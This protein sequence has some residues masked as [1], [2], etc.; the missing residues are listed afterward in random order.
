MIPEKI[1]FTEEESQII[2]K[3]STYY[4]AAKE[5][6][7]YGEQI[8]PNNRTLA[9][10]LSERSN[11]L[12]HILRVFLEKQGLRDEPVKDPIAYNRDSLNKAYGHIY[13]AAYDALDWVALT[14][15]ERLAKD[16]NSVSIEA[17][18][19]V[20]PEYYSDIKPKLEKILRDDITSLRDHKD[21]TDGNEDNL[22]SY[23]QT[24]VTIRQLFDKVQEKMSSLIEYNL[25]HKRKERLNLVWQ[26][27]IAIIA[28]IVLIGV[29]WLIAHF[30]GG[31]ATKTT[32]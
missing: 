11:A 31:N 19:A 10:L 12:D 7:I 6:I 4:R 30:T 25:K 27:I 14:I 32:P 1:V 8:D 15:Q 5:L 18:S 16:I 21:V 24:V 29:G 17:V 28:G 22:E 13:R 23:I 20:M 3:I 2:R 26:I 9:Q